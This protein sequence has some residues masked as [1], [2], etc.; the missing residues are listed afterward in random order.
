M[1]CLNARQAVTASFS[2]GNEDF[3]VPAGK[4]LGVSSDVLPLPRRL[5][6]VSTHSNAVNCSDLRGRRWT[7]ITDPVDFLPRSVLTS[8]LPD[9]RRGEHLFIDLSVPKVSFQTRLLC[10]KVEEKMRGMIGEWLGFLDCDEMAPLHLSIASGGPVYMLSGLGPGFTPAGDDFITGWITAKHCDGSRRACTEVRHFYENWNADGT[11]WFS[12]WM[13]KDAARGR[14]WRRGA[15]LIRAI[16]R[17]ICA[18]DA[19]NDIFNWGHSSGRAWLAGLAYGFA[20][21]S[22]SHGAVKEMVLCRS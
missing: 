9:A 11:T 7:F 6:V 16:G 13:I 20:Q 10:V 14:I 15:A 19:L 8:T 4:T 12:K 18:A 2:R 3:I 5:K 17:G 22:A 21:G 1:R